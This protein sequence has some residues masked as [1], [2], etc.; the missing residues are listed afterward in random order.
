MF[1]FRTALRC[2]F[3]AYSRRKTIY[4]SVSTLK[5]VKYFGHRSFDLKFL[6]PKFYEKLMANPHEDNSEKL[7]LTTFIQKNKIRSESKKK[8]KKSKHKYSKTKSSLSEDGTPIHLKRKRKHSKKKKRKKID[9]S[10]SGDKKRER[11]VSQSSDNDIVIIFD[12][13]VDKEKETVVTSV[14]KKLEV[15][16]TMGTSFSES[17]A[18]IPSSSVVLNVQEN[19]VSSSA[20]V[21]NMQGWQQS[22]LGWMYGNDFLTSTQPHTS[23]DSFVND[24]NYVFYS[25][26]HYRGETFIRHKETRDSPERIKLK[27]MRTWDFT[28]FGNTVIGKMKESS[29]NLKFTLLSYN[30]L[31]Q[32]LLCSHPYLYK[33]HHNETLKWKYRSTL[34]LKEIREADADVSYEGIYKKRTGDNVD[35][36]AIYY[37]KHLFDMVHFTTVEYYQPGVSVLDRHNVGLV[38]KL[39]VKGT[40]FQQQIVVATTHLLFNPRR[41]DVKLAQMQIL[42]AEV[43]RF[44]FRSESNGIPAYWPVIITGDMNFEPKS[45]VYKF[46]TQGMLRYEGLTSRTL[47]EIPDDVVMKTLLAS[48]GLIHNTDHHRL[49]QQLNISNEDTDNK[50]YEDLV[51]NAKLDG[52]VNNFVPFFGPS[53]IPPMPAAGFATGQ[54]IHNLNLR[55]VYSPEARKATTNQGEWLTV[56][57]IFYSCQKDL[58]EGELKLV[59]SYRLLDVAG[60][61]HMGPIPNW[62]SPS[63]HYPLLA[64]F[65]LQQ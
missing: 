14:N 55:S 64:A 57:Y 27:A 53:P 20:F 54:L 17:I 61:K 59:G 16:D 28:D 2:L 35:G 29:Q 31:A 48:A 56:D 1:T 44:A 52:L 10:V 23:S 22:S 8:H 13:K 43:E 4:S 21:Q 51:N 34:L 60:A 26:D 50:S 65:Y 46:L 7:K 36:V 32:D 3:E 39:A 40:A 25:D 62:A 33:Y 5:N 19:P 9:V 42:L 45:G 18:S 30:V 37:K 47:S 38:A 49:R 63:D 11:A 58:Q 24:V 6:Y 12:S 15:C 41:H